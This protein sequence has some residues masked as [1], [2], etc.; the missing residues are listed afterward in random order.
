MKDH[1]SSNAKPHSKKPCLALPLHQAIRDG[2]EYFIDKLFHYQCAPDI[3]TTDELGLSPLHLAVLQKEQGIARIL[4]KNGANVNAK[5]SESKMLPEKVVCFAAAH[6]KI[7]VLK[8]ML[9]NGTQLKDHFLVQIA[10]ANGFEDVL[11]LFIKNGVD[12]SLPISEYQIPLF[13]AVFNR[14]SWKMVLILNLI[15]VQLRKIKL[16]KVPFKLQL[17]KMIFF[18]LG[19]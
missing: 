11:K 14:D 13:E 6:G 15:V 16:A 12:V 4:I 10:A 3:N 2:D 5:S 8:M 19:L 7:K 9:D 1:K 18:Q 17:N